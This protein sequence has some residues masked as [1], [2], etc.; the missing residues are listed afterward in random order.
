MKASTLLASAL[1][2]AVLVAALAAGPAAQDSGDTA[3]MPPRS[4]PTE[5]HK[6]LHRKV[7][8][9]DATVTTEG[10]PES[11]AV[12]VA[13]LD[14]GGLWLIGD[15]RGEFGGSEFTGHE[16]QGYDTEKGKYVS[17]WVDSWMD[18][19]M[20]LEGTWDEASQTL[21][22]WTESKDP[23]TG[24]PMKERHDTQFVDEKTFTFTMNYPAPDGSYAPVMKITYKRR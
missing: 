15:Y 7:G 1:T 14:H 23:T 16:V 11:K 19:A 6:L 17:T 4:T 3:G 20:H 10:M 5:H 8:T 13:K 24:K 9:W 12:F 18:H 22:M 2:A 21:T